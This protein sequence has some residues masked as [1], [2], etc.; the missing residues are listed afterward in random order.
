MGRIGYLLMAFGFLAAWLVPVAGVLVM[1]VGAILT[2]IAS[3]RVI[4]PELLDSPAST[5]QSAG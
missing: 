3:E 4:L 2:A 5:R 1:V